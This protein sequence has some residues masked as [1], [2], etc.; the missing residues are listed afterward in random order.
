MF[1]LSS[2]VGRIHCFVHRSI[3]EQDSH[4]HRME[5]HFGNVIASDDHTS[6]CY[7]VGESPGEKNYCFV[8]I[9]VLLAGPLCRTNKA[10]QYK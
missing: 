1:L 4:N 6:I 5:A 9:E 7:C 8:S 3:F 2:F 10:I